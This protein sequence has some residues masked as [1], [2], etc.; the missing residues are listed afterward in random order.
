[1]IVGSV[2]F[3]KHYG[4]ILVVM[5]YYTIFYNK[6]KGNKRFNKNTNSCIYFCKNSYYDANFLATNFVSMNETGLSIPLN[7]ENA[8]IHKNAL[9]IF[10]YK[11]CTF[12]LHGPFG[13]GKSYT[14]AI[15]QRV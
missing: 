1:M 11:F 14:L 5:K 10:K 3:S 9:H 13:I 8:N 12:L 2:Y 15:Y 6:K 7:F 4:S